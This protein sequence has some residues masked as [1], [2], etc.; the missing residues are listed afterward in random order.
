MSEESQQ[1]QSGAAPPQP[2]EGTATTSRA[3]LDA[4]RRA[5]GWRVSP[6][7]VAA[8]LA[9]IESA[10]QEPTPERVARIAAATRG[11]RSQRQRRH[12][13]LWRR[14]GAQLALHGQ[15]S[16]PEAQRAF[17]G[18][19]R[20]IAG[21]RSDALALRV[22]LAVADHGGPLDARSVGEITRWLLR[23]VGE[24]PADE[25]IAEAVPAAIQAI[26]E[27]RSGADRPPRPGRRRRG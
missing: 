10:G 18:R 7:E 11:E 5:A 3:F 13:D 21:I 16:D 15:P 14:L 8:A 17:I 4:V 19:V 24:V 9:A 23:R 2:S 6:R 12:P 27:S 20:A 26:Q 1:D 25:A 22:A